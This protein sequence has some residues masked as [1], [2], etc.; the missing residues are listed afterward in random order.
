MNKIVEKLSIK[1]EDTFGASIKEKGLAFINKHPE[2][3][4]LTLLAVSCLIF[5]FWGLNAYPLMD[6]DETRYAV[7]ARALAHSLNWNDLMLNSV[8]FLEKP[9]LYFWLVA[10]SINFFR[11]FSPFVVRLPI[12]LLTTFLIFSTY[13]VGKRVIS[14]KFGMLSALTLLSSIF[15]LILSHVAIIDMVLTVFVTSALYCG[16]LTHFCE[17]KN[18]K[19]YWWYFYMFIGLGFLAKGL[20]ALALT[21]TIM[22]IYNL[23]TKTA[24]EMFKPL[25]LI[26]GIL[27]L[28]VM[29]VP[30]HYV[31]Y[32]E[33]GYQFIKEYF[34]LHHFGRL[35]GSETIG[36]E[37]P[38]FYFVPV[39]LLGFL[40]WTFA[41]ISF[42]CDGFK[43][44]TAKFKATEGKLKEKIAAILE[45]N[46]NEQ[47]LI[48][49]A[50][51][52]FI[53]VLLVFSSSSTKLPTYILP[54]FPAAALLTGYYWWVSD[55]RNEHAKSIHN[56]TI[57]FAVVLTLA[58]IVGSI[59]FYFLP[60]IIQNKLDSFK[61]QTVMAFY[62]LAIY[63][64]LR[65]KTKRA[66]SIFS[67][68]IL[69]MIFI[70]ILASTKIFNFVYLT[71]Q[72]ELVDYSMYSVAAETPSQLVTFDFAVKP[73]AM[74]HSRGTVK[75]ITDPDFEELDKALLYK[76]GPTF[77]II[78]NKNMINNE[79]YK[80]DITKRLELIE[81]GEKY[82][83]YVKDIN[84]SYNKEE[85]LDFQ[86]YPGHM[87]L[88]PRELNF[89]SP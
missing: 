34:L 31:M 18:K 77:V 22:F 89:P 41:F 36:R 65:L 10:S 32:K 64:I 15:F 37:R 51:I 46:T 49:F 70:I 6:V 63:L 12:A 24:K 61:H 80:N 30:W 25:Y 75:F 66:L 27:I 5:L 58:A 74:I 79:K 26:P 71:G 72:N 2:L 44:L 62:L 28:L 45:A 87:P 84:N 20:L 21:V 76:K 88:D 83:L 11:D 16:F 47:K 17:E 35:I 23:I 1:A 7:M 3:F 8:P 73:S 38:L 86:K 85:R 42:V 81:E 14:R 39:F 50:S 13:Y 60:N 52:F 69:T 29:I 54:L 68:Y 19:F 57:A 9:P 48:L 4:C 56:S 43:K 59:S 82:S 55:E 78:K 40:P 33:Y 67:G 53:V